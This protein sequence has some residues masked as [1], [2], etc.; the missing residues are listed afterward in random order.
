[1][2]EP[3]F[4][5]TRIWSEPEISSD[6]NFVGARNFVR[7]DFPEETLVVM[8]AIAI[9]VIAGVAMAKVHVVVIAV[10]VAVVVE[11]VL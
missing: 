9:V 6:K 10:L 4:F 1:M 2:S 7:Q 3:G 5:R 11:V 8:V